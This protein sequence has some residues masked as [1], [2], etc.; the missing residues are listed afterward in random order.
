M[1]KLE[2]ELLA[3]AGAM[4]SWS[5]EHLELRAESYKLEQLTEAGAGA[6]N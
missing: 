5:Y 4:S 2:L 3:E 1:L 6:T